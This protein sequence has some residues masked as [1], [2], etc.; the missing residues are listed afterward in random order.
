MNRLN[1][2]NKLRTALES[3]EFEVWFQPR[4]RIEDSALMG[5]EALVRWRSPELN[6]VP[7]AEFIPL[8]E[9]TGLIIPIGEWVLRTACEECL[10]WQPYTDEQ[11]PLAVSVNFS[12][13]QFAQE[14]L[15]DK[16]ARLIREMDISPQLLELELTES[17]IMPNADETIEILKAL[18]KLGLTI[19][20]DDF[21]TG[22]SSLSYLKRFPIDILKIDRSFIF[23]MVQATSE[24]NH[25]LVTAIIAMAHKLRLEVV[26]EG[27]ETE[28]QL[29]FLREHQC[30]YVQGYLFGEPMP[31]K[32]FQQALEAGRKNM[33]DFRK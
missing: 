17:L 33:E 26:A 31:A 5:A 11:H 18:K 19:S 22:Y 16:T 30:N 32:E 23:D 12:A 9:D 1:M 28:A 13:R 24:E 8:A 29:A 21:G 20:V 7:P 4:F 6:L 10:Q 25:T 27:V 3:R 2:E 15:L 14:D